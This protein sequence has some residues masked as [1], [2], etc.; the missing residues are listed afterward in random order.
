MSASRRALAL[1]L[2]LGLLSGCGVVGS[3]KSMLGLGKPLTS[4]R[5]LSVSADP[6]AN[7]GNATQ[8]DI[9]VTFTDNATVSLPKTGPDWFRQRAALQSALATD[10]VVVSLQVPSASAAF[11]VKLPKRS[12]KGVAVYAF[13]NYVAPQGWSPI[14]LT[15]YKRVALRLQENAVAVTAK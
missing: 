10:I 14:A 8:L 3:V 6:G 12:K 5:S 1:L 15:P 2:T 4:L 7:Q 9:V 13:A 11:K